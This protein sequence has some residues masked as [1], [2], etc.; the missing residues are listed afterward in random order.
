M[1]KGFSYIEILISIAL[2]GI[3]IISSSYTMVSIIK[4]K[5]RIIYYREFYKFMN[6]VWNKKDFQALP[7]K[8][9]GKKIKIK[10]EEKEN[11]IYL[12]IIDPVSG[13]KFFV[14][15]SKIINL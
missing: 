7:E 13:R 8:I 4:L 15:Y 12:T 3:L 6:K 10:K 14:Y 2:I 1:N 5:K 11:E 9:R